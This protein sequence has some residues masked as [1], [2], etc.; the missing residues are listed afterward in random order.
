MSKLLDGISALGF[1]EDEASRLAEK[2]DSYIKEIQLFNKTAN[3]V[4]TDDYDTLAVHHVL[5]CLAGANHFRAV[6]EE[7][8]QRNPALIIG[9]IGSGSG[10]PGIVLAAVFPE[11]NFKLIERMKKRCGFLE[12]TAAVLALKNV[13]VV[14]KDAEKIKKES[15]DVA[16][17]RAFRPL[18]AE[19]T[20]TILSM[21]KAGGAVVA[22]KARSEKIAEEMA[23]I[24]DLVVEYK[25]IPLSVPFLT[26][27]TAD[28]RERNLVIFSR[29]LSC[30]GD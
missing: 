16:T 22:Y 2:M 25:K 1:D 20:K 9:D 17:F 4:G 23:G 21:L 6:C 14:N 27:N 3:L 11:Y 15:L 18:T 30:K 24:K 19:M 10:F 7:Q 26:E 12:N 29:R 13:E 8:K 5:D 28:P